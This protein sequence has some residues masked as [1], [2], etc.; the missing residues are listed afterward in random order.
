MSVN[1]AEDSNRCEVGTI[2][3]QMQL[4]TA[5]QMC[6]GRSCTALRRLAGVPHRPLDLASKRYHSSSFAVPRFGTAQHA[7]DDDRT[8]VRALEQF[9]VR[10]AASSDV[11]ARP[12]PGDRWLYTRTAVLHVS[13]ML[14]IATFQVRFSIFGHSRRWAQPK[15]YRRLE[16]SSERVL[17]QKGVTSLREIS[18]YLLT[19]P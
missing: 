13:T 14:R 11:G 4:V 1:Y 19:R 9:R 5:A 16:R 3:G 10:S 18:A 12:L 7:V 8:D 2:W 17:L 15:A 6:L